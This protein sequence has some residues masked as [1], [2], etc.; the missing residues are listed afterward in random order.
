MKFQ[1]K[2]TTTGKGFP[3]FFQ[4]G[5][6][7]NLNQPQQLLGKQKNVQLISMDCPGHGATPLPKGQIPSF[8]FHYNND[9]SSWYCYDIEF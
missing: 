2:Y 4:H 8:N 9:R 7:A 3:F 1:H 5:L 6:G